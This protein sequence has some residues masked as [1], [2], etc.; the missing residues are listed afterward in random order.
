MQNPDQFAAIFGAVPPEEIALIHEMAG[1]HPDL[2][3]AWDL[4]RMLCGIRPIL[5][6]DP[7]FAVPLTRRQISE[8]LAYIKSEEDVDGFI[9]PIAIAWLRRER[10]AKPVAEITAPRE[11]QRREVADLT[12]EEQRLLE[13]YGF[14][15]DLFKAHRS[16][17]AARAE[18]RW[19]YERLMDLKPMMDDAA[20]KEIVRQC[21]RNELQLRRIDDEMMQ[22]PMVQFKDGRRSDGINPQFED[23]QALKSK[24]EKTYA[25]QWE[26]VTKLSPSLSAKSNRRAAQGVMSEY[27]EGTLKHHQD[28]NNQ[29]LD[30]V[31]TAFE[32]QVLMRKS[33]QQGMQYR[34]GWVAAVNESK[35]HLTDPKFK[36]RLPDKHCR[37][38]DESFRIAE[39]RLG[40]TL[41][42]PDLVSTG[43]DGE[44][45]ALYEPTEEDAE[46][47]DTVEEE[48]NI[49]ADL[50]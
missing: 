21:L 50:S 26:Q 8:Q 34:P 32:I 48:E 36:R 17:S 18:M 16:E 40:D 39:Q 15:M 30:G 42:K 33:E 28:P 47:K 14:S 22:T 46:I 41:K 13:A 5:N 1:H 9:S 25:E 38:L 20:V 2:I 6:E 44:Y 45:E 29:I 19:F 43:E 3:R 37:V 49:G 7:A 31:F 23:L 4:V 27:I 24:V 12:E 35:N 11:Q 10:Y